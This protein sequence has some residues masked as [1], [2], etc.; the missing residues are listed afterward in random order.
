MVFENRKAAGK[1]LAAELLSLRSAFPIIIALPRGGVPVGYEVAEIF[2]TSLNVLVARKIGAP[3]NSEFAIGAIAEGDV[4]VL[5]ES[6]I[7]HLEISKEK[8]KEVIKNEKEELKRRVA[9]YRSNRPLPVMK[10]RTI[11]LVDDGLATGSTAR[12]AIVSIKRRKPKQIIFA[13]PVCAYD[14]ELELRSLVDDVIC[15]TKP[16]DFSAVGQWY[17]NF[18]QVTDQEVMDL[19]AQSKMRRRAVSLKG[20]KRMAP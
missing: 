6:P 19:L 15:I 4:K 2:H 5:D 10:G 7:K 13:T 1:R 8:L 3:G 9:L 20:F 11:I 16:V 18:E 12:A 14:T 17:K